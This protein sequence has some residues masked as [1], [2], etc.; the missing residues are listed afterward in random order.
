MSFAVKNKTCKGTLC[1]NLVAN[2]LR[3]LATKKLVFD[4]PNLVGF[5]GPI[6]V[7][8]PSKAWVWGRSLAARDCGFE[9][10]RGYGYLSVQCSLFCR[11]RSRR[12]ADHTSGLVL[13]RAC[14]SMN[15]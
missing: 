15:V 3:L 8:A 4:K 9:S 11:Y 6:S 14:E 13:P 1:G 7:A 5:K 12:R 10:G 2:D